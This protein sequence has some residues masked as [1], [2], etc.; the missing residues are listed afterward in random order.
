MALPVL[1]NKA[2][3]IGRRIFVH[4]FSTEQLCSFLYFPFLTL[5]IVKISLTRVFVLLQMQ[6]FLVTH[7][8]QSHKMI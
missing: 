5:F 2:G 8:V 6:S 4:L 3:D 1:T 7:T